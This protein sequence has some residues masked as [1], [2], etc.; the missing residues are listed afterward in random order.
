MLLPI[1]SRRRLSTL[2]AAKLF[3]SR[4]FKLI[5]PPPADLSAGQTNLIGGA[6]SNR[7]LVRS[8]DSRVSSDSKAGAARPLLVKM[9]HH[10]FQVSQVFEA[11]REAFQFFFLSLFL[12]WWQ[13]FAKD[14]WHQCSTRLSR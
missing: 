4:A 9:Q 8:H 13:E 5:A 14:T 7:S 11:K 12:S 10:A 6:P 2:G 1:I 3:P